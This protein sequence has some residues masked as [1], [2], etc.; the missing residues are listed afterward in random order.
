VQ[1]S[2]CTLGSQLHRTQAKSPQG[3]SV[4]NIFRMF[5]ELV[6]HPCVSAQASTAE[7]SARA[8]GLV[9]DPAE[10]LGK[11]TETG[12]CTCDMLRLSV[13]IVEKQFDRP[14]LALNVHRRNLRCRNCTWSTQSLGSRCSVS[15]RRRRRG[16]G[17][18]HLTILQMR[19]QSCCLTRI[20]D[21]LPHRTSGSWCLIPYSL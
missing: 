5:A 1:I 4:E 13:C 6:V 12:G 2:C 11:N 15:P 16:R 19:R 17:G 7:L 8:C 18:E 20:A 3:P 9:L 10:A 21:R 14:F